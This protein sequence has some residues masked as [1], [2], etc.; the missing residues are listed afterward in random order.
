MKL[1]I[2]M[3]QGKIILI[4]G[5][6]G[7]GKGTVVKEIVK[8]QKYALSVSVTTRNPREGEIDGVNYFFTTKEDFLRRIE[9]NLMLEYAQYNGNFYGTPKDYVEQTVAQG[10]NIIL[11]IEVQGVEQVKKLIPE[12]VSI[13]IMPDKSGVIEHRLRKRG[14]EDEQTIQNR[15]KIALDEMKQAHKYDYIVINGELERCIEDI[16]SVI[17]AE[18]YKKDNMLDFVKGVLENDEKTLCQ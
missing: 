5:P 14:T 16:K 2:T 6:S 17:N 10:K 4:S 1:V 3:D 7:V 11:E 15:L 18:Q 12:A 9:N 8:D 13:F